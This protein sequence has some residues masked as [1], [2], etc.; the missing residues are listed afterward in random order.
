MAD[1]PGTEAIRCNGCQGSGLDTAGRMYKPGDPNPNTPVPAGRPVITMWTGT[2]CPHCR[3]TGWMRN[4][5]V[6]P[7]DGETGGPWRAGR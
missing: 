3:G 2:R 5:P 1:E 4:G 6:D 7:P